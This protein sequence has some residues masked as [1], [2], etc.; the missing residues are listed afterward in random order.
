MQGGEREKRKKERGGQGIRGEWIERRGREWTG[1]PYVSLNFP[2]NS[3]WQNYS[4]TDRFHWRNI[5]FFYGGSNRCRKLPAACTV[6]I[7]AVLN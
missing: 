5:S 3:L 6:L 1:P 7:L 4:R 2:Q